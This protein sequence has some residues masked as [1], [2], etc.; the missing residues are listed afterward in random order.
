MPDADASPQLRAGGAV[1]P[2][3]YG[4]YASTF[5]SN[6]VASTL[7]WERDA[8]PARTSPEPSPVKEQPAPADPTWRH[9]RYLEELRRTGANQQG[10][11]RHASNIQIG[12]DN[13]GRFVGHVSP[14]ARRPGAGRQLELERPPDA[15]SPSMYD[16]ET[17]KWIHRPSPIDAAS[18]PAGRSPPNLSTSPERPGGLSPERAMYV[19]SSSLAAQVCAHPLNIPS[20]PSLAASQSE[21]AAVSIA[22]VVCMPPQGPYSLPKAPEGEYTK[23]LERKA[24]RAIF[25]SANRSPTREPRGVGSSFMVFH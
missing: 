5:S 13:F 1:S 21:S 12:T 9:L 7:Q 20:V 17:R 6:A 2:Q 18:P 10:P 15:P 8:P 23:L 24:Q 4:A 19:T 22:S 14:V 3:R 11:P 16:A 25:A